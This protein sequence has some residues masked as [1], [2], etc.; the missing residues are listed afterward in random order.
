MKVIQ[1]SEAKEEGIT[2]TEYTKMAGVAYISIPAP[3]KGQR[4]LS[5]GPR[6]IID[7]DPKPELSHSD[8]STSSQSSDVSELKKYNKQLQEENQLLKIETRDFEQKL[9]YLEYSL[10]VVDGDGAADIST[11]ANP[12]NLWGE[13]IN[14]LS[15]DNIKDNNKNDDIT[16]SDIK[17]ISDEKEKINKDHHQDVANGSELSDRPEEMKRL[18]AKNRNMLRAIKAL[19]KAAMAQKNKHD[20]YK[21]K[22]SISKKEAIAVTKKMKETQASFIKTRSLFLQEKD[23]KEEL[24]DEINRLA[25]QLKKLT[26]TNEVEKVDME[27]ILQELEEETEDKKMASQDTYTSDS[28]SDPLQVDLMRKTERIAQLNTKVDKVMKYMKKTVEKKSKNPSSAYTRNDRFDDIS[29]KST[30][31]TSETEM[32]I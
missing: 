15:I 12:L 24:Q 22:L 18:L 29:N 13:G 31:S 25:P 4:R 27:R 5:K 8:Q 11:Y 10:G 14:N 16:S 20:H 3:P 1:N 30:K 32:S 6:Q 28:E 17:S 23:K 7:V 26:A 19:A 9:A 2:I 21:S